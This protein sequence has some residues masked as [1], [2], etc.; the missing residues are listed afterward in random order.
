[1]PGAKSWYSRF[2]SLVGTSERYS[3]PINEFIFLLGTATLFYPQRR[4]AVSAVVQFS[5]RLHDFPV[6]W[7]S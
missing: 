5:G 2:R 3:R 7:A 6:D 1:M 4:L